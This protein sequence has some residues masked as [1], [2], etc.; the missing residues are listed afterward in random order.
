MEGGAEGRR[1]CLIIEAGEAIGKR[2]WEDVNRLRWT[3]N[4]QHFNNYLCHF[5]GDT[6]VFATWDRVLQLRNL[7]CKR[8]NE[9]GNCGD[10]IDWN[11]LCLRIGLYQALRPPVLSSNHRF[12]GSLH[13]RAA[14]SVD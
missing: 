5:E 14:K 2:R 4:I 13:R 7:I 9:T 10:R 8:E 11:S 12:P 1:N 3:P 6:C